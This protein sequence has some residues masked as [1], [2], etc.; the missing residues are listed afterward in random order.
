[1]KLIN[2][3]QLSE[4]NSATA[5]SDSDFEDYVHKLP[6][7]GHPDPTGRYLVVSKEEYDNWD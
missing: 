6:V 1:M 3:S 4:D 5:V 2:K 7:I